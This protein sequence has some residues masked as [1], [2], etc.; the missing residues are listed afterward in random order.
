MSLQLKQGGQSERENQAFD[1]LLKQLGAYELGKRISK[2]PSYKAYDQAYPYDS[3]APIVSLDDVLSESQYIDEPSP[4][5]PEEYYVEAEEMQGLLEPLPEPQRQVIRHTI[6]G[7]KPAEI[8][9]MNGHHDS[10]A[11][12]QSKYHALRALQVP[13]KLEKRRSK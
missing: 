10:N 7:Y 11:V 6:N 1:N 4:K 2:L 12:R 8:A 13:I 3:V 9:N 5:T